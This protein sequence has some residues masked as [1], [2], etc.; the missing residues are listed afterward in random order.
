[1]KI[2]PQQYALSLYE[3]TADQPREKQKEI[4]SLFVQ[5]LSRKG[6]FKLWPKISEQFSKIHDEKNLTAEIKVFSAHK[7]SAENKTD[8]ANNLKKNKLFSG[9]KNFILREFEDKN[10]IGGFRLEYGDSV[11][12]LSVISRLESLKTTMKNNSN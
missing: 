4:I 2:K 8:L 12:D 3:L 11:I 9:Y 7:L 5:F 6:D 1:M 10:L